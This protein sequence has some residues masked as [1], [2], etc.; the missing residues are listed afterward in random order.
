MVTYIPDKSDVVWLE[1]DP[2]SGH[3]QNGKRPAV[4]ISP[5]NDNEKSNLALFCPVTSKVKGYPFE[6]KISSK[7]ISGVILSDQIK[8]L[9]WKARKAEFIMKAS[10]S[11]MDDVMSKLKLLL[12]N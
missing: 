1:F 12:F 8:S 4:V 11:I 10:D 3:E 9:D 2:Q 7:K 5:K 6:V